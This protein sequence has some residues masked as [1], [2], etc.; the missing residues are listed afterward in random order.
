MVYIWIY[1]VPDFPIPSRVPIFLI[2]HYVTFVLIYDGHTFCID[3]RAVIRAEEDTEDVREEDGIGVG[4]A[5]TGGVAARRNEPE[6]GLKVTVGFDSTP[7]GTFSGGNYAAFI[8]FAR[9]G[10][11]SVG[12]LHIV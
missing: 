9:N 4:L 12:R 7:C 6:N 10:T 5:L 8:R 3:K 11:Y 2:Y 1:L